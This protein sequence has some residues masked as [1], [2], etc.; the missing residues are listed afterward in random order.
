MHRIMKI[1]LGILALIACLFNSWITNAQ[2]L[3]ERYDLK[4]QCTD[5]CRS[6]WIDQAFHCRFAR[7]T[8]VLQGGNHPLRIAF[9][10]LSFKEVGMSFSLVQSIGLPVQAKGKEYRITLDYKAREITKMSYIASLLNSAGQKVQ[11]DTLVLENSSDWSEPTL[12]LPW[13]PDAKAVEIR[14]NYRADREN[15]HPEQTVW[16]SGIT[17]R[18]DEADLGNRVWNEHS[19]A[20]SLRLVKSFEPRYVFP[21]SAE[22]DKKFPFH[23][24]P[25]F[26]KKKVI[27]LG[28]FSLGSH[29]V[30]GSMFESARELITHHRATWVLIEWPFDVSVVYDLY[31]QGLAPSGFEKSIRESLSVTGWDVEMSLDFIDWVREYNRTAERKVHLVGIDAWA[32]PLAN[33]I[34]YEYFETLLGKEKGAY[35]LDLIRKKRYDKLTAVVREDQELERFMGPDNYG[36]LSYFL[37]G[38][39]NV[40]LELGG[41]LKEEVNRYREMFQGYSNLVRN[42]KEEEKCILL[43]HHTHIARDMRRI[44]L[45]TFTIGAI[46]D[47]QEKVEKKSD[48]YAISFQAGTGAIRRPDCSEPG[49]TCIKPLPPAPYNSFESVALSCGP[50]YFYYP[51]RYL[52][53]DLLQY[54][55]LPTYSDPSN[56]YVF[57]SPKHRFDAIV[58]IRESTPARVPADQPARAKA[59][60]E[61]KST[62]PVDRPNEND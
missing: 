42:L 36:L 8:T 39:R 48:Y 58:F 25:D 59:W 56:G 32:L 3:D 17:L 6:P 26:E 13:V 2:T 33:S 5:A 57:A 22:G 15:R 38:Y 53:D 29:E 47:F 9:E 1:R 11:A 61:K 44:W 30:I 19:A 12:T 14:L 60:L 21:L 49:R 55:S 62:L 18:L 27:G 35:Y 34:L 43:A 28:G 16:L 24:I 23:T 10:P 51:T 31:V 46:S 50:D 37:S 20:D 40:S 7:D 45:P 52:G 41:Y 4:F 54:L